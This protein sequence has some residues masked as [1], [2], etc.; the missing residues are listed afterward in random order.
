M[1]DS[2]QQPK[3]PPTFDSETWHS[4]AHPEKQPQWASYGVTLDVLY[5][6]INVL[7]L[8]KYRLGQLMGLRPQNVY[9]WFDGRNRPNAR[10]MTQLSKLVLMVG[11]DKINLAHVE[12][13]DWETGAITYTPGHEGPSQLK[14]VR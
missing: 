6:L 1:D 9:G 2:E 5:G 3:M 7:G 12:A 4:A 10:H 8:S 13:I 11:V 14:H